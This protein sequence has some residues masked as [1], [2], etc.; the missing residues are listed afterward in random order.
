[1]KPGR[2]D[3][4]SC[5]SGKKYKRC[6]GQEGLLGSTAEASRPREGLAAAELDQLVT[7]A[8]AGR[9]A[10]V[11]RRAGVLLQQWPD[12]GAL[13]RVLGFALWMQGKDAVAVLQKTAHLLPNDAEAHGNLGTALRAR[14]QLADAIDCYRRALQIAPDFAEA[15]NN[16][17]CAYRDLGQL[18]DAASSY[19]RALAIK[20]DFAVAHCNLGQALRLLT[21]FDEAAM[22]YRR[23]VEIQPD[24]V[25]AHTGLGNAL[26]E[27]GRL[28]DA[29]V[30]HRRTLALQPNAAESYQ[31]LGNTFLDLLRLDDAEASYRQALALNP[32]IA[33]VHDRLGVTLRTKGRAAEAEASSRSALEINPNLV[34]AHISVAQ[35]LSDKGQFGEAEDALQRAISIEPESATAWAGI[36]GLRRMTAGD[37]AWAIEAQR[38]AAK[39]LP[40]RREAHLRFAIG[41]YFDDVKD[42]DQAFIHYRRANELSKLY[43]PKH[44]RQQVAREF[45][46]IIELQDRFWVDNASAAANPSSRPVLVVGMPRSGTT[47]TEQILSAHPGVFGAGEVSFWLGASTKFLSVQSDEGEVAGIINQLA[48]AYLRL[49]NDQSADALRVVDK[50]PGNFQCLGLIRAALPNA[51]IIH[52]QRNPIDTCLSIYFHDFNL[53]H[54]YANDLEDLAHFYNEY[55]R[56]MQH[57]HSA[58]PVGAILD[59]SYE[60]L[61][62]D[63]EAWSRKMIEFIGLPWDPRCLDFDTSDRAGR[64]GRTIMTFSKWQ[65]RQKISKSS[66]DRWRNYEKFIGPLGNLAKTGSQS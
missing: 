36:A 57:W 34:A 16:L 46:R 50:M 14:G 19:R 15:H 37:A 39:P 21:R 18:E 9:H 23:A 4:C 65:A 40:L 29:L 28:E 42:F 43:A 66:V 63:Q 30:S 38:I 59:V 20:P 10:E 25:E 13:W 41:K 6:C 49:L 44:D 52:L 17:G 58:L 8:N 24:Y 53:T 2:N 27:L 22:H 54:T 64:E 11:E 45:D 62:E 32:R 48:S 7:L 1:V 33:E 55:L 5:G 3:P 56:L 35:L 12:S 61:V 47:L 26:Q 31:A 51:R 60:G